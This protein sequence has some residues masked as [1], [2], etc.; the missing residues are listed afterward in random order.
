MGDQKVVLDKLAIVAVVLIII[1]ALNWGWIG[2]TGTNPVHWANTYTFNS[3][4]LER[5]IY[6]IIGIAGLFA[7]YK[8]IAGARK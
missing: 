8:L 5:I 7:L 3:V 6:V 4:A 2:L 1:G